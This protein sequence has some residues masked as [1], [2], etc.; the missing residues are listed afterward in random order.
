MGIKG[1]DCLLVKKDV[2]NYFGKVG[3]VENCWRIGFRF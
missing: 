1:L 2:L 3:F